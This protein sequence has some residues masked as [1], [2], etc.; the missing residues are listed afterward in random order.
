MAT[1]N[2]HDRFADA[3]FRDPAEAGVVFRA[4]LPPALVQ[5]LDFARAELQPR[6]FTSDELRQR[7]SDF[8]FRVPL[9][10][11]GEVFLLALLEHQSTVDPLMAARLLVYAGRALDR[12]L[13]EHPEANEVPALIPVVLFHGEGGW[14]AATE[15]FE[16]YALPED[17]R[18]VVRDYVPALR[19]AVD[20]LD[21]ASDDE[22]RQRDGPVLA[23][24]ALI[25]LRHAQELRTAADPAATMR[26]L[27]AAVGDLLRQVLDR[28]GRTVV[29]RYMLE[30]VEL[31]AEEGE[32]ILVQAM[33][34]PM[35]EDVV[36][37]ADQLRAE[38]KREGERE[39]E[40]RVLL[41]LLKKGFGP[42]PSWVEGRVRGASDAEVEAWTDRV[43]SA[44]TLSEVFSEDASA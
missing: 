34:E 2:P 30:L 41:R 10:A 19:Y 35:K 38:G 42:L 20:D 23:R 16:L 27:A 8:L 18:P 25:V 22:L 13:R 44:S 21:S 26:S 39:G 4:V 5:E 29:F 33:P 7:R 9:R 36:T 15:L 43:L 3:V 14:N 11:G 31:P 1:S 12:F 28:T 40:R 32:E 37:A 6:L 24:L 17:L